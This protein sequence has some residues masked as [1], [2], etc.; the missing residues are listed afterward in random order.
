M[1]LITKRKQTINSRVQLLCYFSWHA[2]VCLSLIFFFSS[3]DCSLSSRGGLFCLLFLPIFLTYSIIIQNKQ[4]NKTLFRDSV[5]HEDMQDID[6]FMLHRLHCLSESMSSSYEAYNMVAAS[7]A[8]SAF[9]NSYLN[10]FSFEIY[11]DR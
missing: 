10:S 3:C 7:Q 6:Q 1:I 8:L 4:T 2:C 9:I 11:K 5:Q